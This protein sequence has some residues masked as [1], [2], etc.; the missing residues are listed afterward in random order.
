MKKIC[1]LLGLLVPALASA[2]YTLSA[3]ESAVLEVV[4]RDELDTYIA[5]G[6]SL[7]GKRLGLPAVTAEAVSQ[8]YV[9]GPTARFP[10]VLD[11]AMLIVGPV[12][13]G[14]GDGQ[15][16]SFATAGAP[17]VRASLPPGV[18]AAGHLA[19]A[20]SRMA[21]ADGVPTFMDC[22]DGV[23]AGKQE[24]A[25]LKAELD[26]FYQGKPTAVAVSQLAVNI[27][28]YASLL[29][30]GHG[31]PADMDK[32]LQAILATDAASRSKQL[33][34]V[35]RRFQKAGLDLSPYTASATTA[36]PGR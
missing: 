32:C 24:A 29:A 35:V 9:H 7:I 17:A 13:A 4:L 31:C 11:L 2:A 25:R 16:V 21:L 19:L 3:T 1:A 10:A 14:S 23:L 28:V 6:Q 33:P 26:G 5:G 8:A 30:P 15:T 20:C 12:A 27:S 34:A 22:R 36:A 18:T